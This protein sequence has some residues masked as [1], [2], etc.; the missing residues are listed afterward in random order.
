MYSEIK[1]F[2]DKIAQSW[3]NVRHRTIFRE[4]LERVNGMWSGGK[5]LNI[6]CAHGPDFV[7]FDSKKFQFYGTDISKNLLL[8]AKKYSQKFDLTFH[9]TLSDMK[10]LPFKDSS[11]D[12]IICIATLHHLLKRE[13]RMLALSEIKRV[14][15]KEAFLTVWN[16]DN[17]ELPNKEIIEREWHYRGEVFKRKYYLYTKEDLEEE[18]KRVGFEI[19]EIWAD[20]GDRNICALICATKQPS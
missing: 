8:M 20:G 10:K 3:Y 15:K 5:L 7:S 11:F 9:L 6:G 17:A 19:K 13:E 18:L 4:E 16:R 2:Y 14:L 12:Y 1:N